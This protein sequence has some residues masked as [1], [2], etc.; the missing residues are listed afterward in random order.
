MSS[1]EF[2]DPGPGAGINSQIAI[3]RAQPVVLRNNRF[4]IG[5]TLMGSIFAALM[6]VAMV[7]GMFSQLFPLSALNAARGWSALRWSLSALAM[8][9][10]CPWLWKLGRAM[11]GYEVRLDGRGVEFILGTKKAPAN[12]LIAW[13]Q[14]AAIKH[15]RVGNVQQYWVHGTDGSEARFSSYTFFRPKKIARLIATR[16]GMTIQEA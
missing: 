13:D 15:K 16:A 9:Y 8:G 3:N 1:T 12:L 14:I 4:L 2:P 7:L 11:A 10:M 6:A 5:V